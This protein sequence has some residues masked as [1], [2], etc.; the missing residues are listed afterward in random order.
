MVFLD[1]TLRRPTQSEATS[2]RINPSPT[3]TVT[4][5]FPTSQS[6]PICVNPLK[7]VFNL[8]SKWLL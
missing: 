3:K 5:Y 2:G 8:Y 1:I 6:A 7:S 4:V